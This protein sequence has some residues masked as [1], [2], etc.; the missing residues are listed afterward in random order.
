MKSPVFFRHFFA[1]PSQKSSFCFLFFVLDPIFGWRPRVQ[2]QERRHLPQMLRLRRKGNGRHV[3][4]GGRELDR[5][6]SANANYLFLLIFIDFEQI[7]WLVDDILLLSLLDGQPSKAVVKSSTAVKKP[8]KLK[9]VCLV[10]RETLPGLRPSTNVFG[11][12]WLIVH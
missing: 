7:C 4:Q 6:E 3:A 9:I 5:K 1:L 2:D 8:P 10:N 12:G 11:F